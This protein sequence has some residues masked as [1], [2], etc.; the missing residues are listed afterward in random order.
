MP[1]LQTD[2]DEAGQ[3]EVNDRRGILA[4]CAICILAVC[5]YAFIVKRD[6]SNDSARSPEAVAA[7][8]GK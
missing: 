5:V 7:R 2:N 8:A 4:I 6:R 3:E 1:Y